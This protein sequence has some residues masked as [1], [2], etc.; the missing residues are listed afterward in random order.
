MRASDTKAAVGET[1]LPSPTTSTSAPRSSAG[2]AVTSDCEASSST[3]R[4]K[5]AATAG[6]HC[7]T[8][9]VGMTQHG[10]A[11]AH[12]SSAAARSAR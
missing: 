5:E 10:M 7:E 12:S 6:R 4:S 2:S 9:Q 11:A 3:T 8:R 1:C